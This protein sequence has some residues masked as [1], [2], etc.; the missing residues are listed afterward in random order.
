MISVSRS[1][2]ET[3]VRIS[4][5]DALSGISVSTG[6][7]FLDHMLVVFSMYSGLQLSIEAAGDL[8]HHLIEDVAITLGAAVRECIP[9]GCARYGEQT[10]PMDD[11]LVQVVIDLGGRFWYEGRLPSGLYDHFMRSFAENLRSTL[12]LRVLRGFDRH[13][14]IEA[15]MKALGLA[16]RQALAETGTVFSTKGQVIQE[17]SVQC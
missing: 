13:H 4:I 6:D 9:S 1:T 7:K 5:G 8:K 3:S 2:A 11:A 17:I 16:V 14:V 12:H 15:A 10:V